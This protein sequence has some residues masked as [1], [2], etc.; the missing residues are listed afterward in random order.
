MQDI[1]YFSELL[2]NRDNNFACVVEEAVKS[3]L[4]INFN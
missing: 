3:L 2:K 1:K 4:V